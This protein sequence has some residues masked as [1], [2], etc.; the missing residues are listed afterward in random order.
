M[1]FGVCL[2]VLALGAAV[3]SASASA[4][5][6]HVGGEELVSSA[7]L[8]SATKATEGISLSAIGVEITCSAFELKSADILA[9]NGGQI[10]HLA[11]KG[12]HINNQHCTLASTTIESKPLTIEAALGGK[13]PEDAVLLKPTAGTV[14][15]EYKIEGASCGLAQTVKLT[16]KATFL[17]P[18]GREELVEQELLVRAGEGELKWSGASLALAGGA[19]LKLASGKAWSF[20]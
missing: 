14:F 3:G 18:K 7:P 9:H 6:W 19:K 16:G 2:A 8:A 15:A 10:E 13:S 1:V 12:C 11:F 5:S 20:H 4:A 17:L